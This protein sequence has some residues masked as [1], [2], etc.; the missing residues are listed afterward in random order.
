MA[1]PSIFRP[2]LQMAASYLLTY[3]F[4]S[5]FAWT[6]FAGSFQLFMAV[7]CSGK[8]VSPGDDDTLDM[9]YPYKV[10]GILQTQA[11][12]C[13]L[14]ALAGVL[15]LRQGD[16]ALAEAEAAKSAG[17]APAATSKAAK[18]KAKKAA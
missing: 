6:M 10:G 12:G 7:L 4:N 15:M 3:R 17:A 13:V 11:T 8:Y 16:P 14:L 18:K 1:L 5:A 2:L 9:C